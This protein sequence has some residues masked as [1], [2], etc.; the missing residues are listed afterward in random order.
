MPV[1]FHSCQYSLTEHVS[2]YAT[3]NCYREVIKA[4]I[5]Q[6][7]RPEALCLQ[8]VITGVEQELPRRGEKADRDGGAEKKFMATVKADIMCVCMY[9]KEML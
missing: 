6:L 7:Q 4:V 5:E 1:L 3:A 9:F 8:R 2:T